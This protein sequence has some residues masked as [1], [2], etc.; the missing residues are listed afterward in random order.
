MI[1]GKWAEV[2]TNLGKTS[3]ND[4]IKMPFK[5]KKVGASQHKFFLKCI[6]VYR[7]FCKQ[8]WSWPTQACKKVKGSSIQKKAFLIGLILICTDMAMCIDSWMTRTVPGCP[9]CQGWGRSCCRPCPRPSPPSP[10]GSHLLLVSWC[11]GVNW[12]PLRLEDFELIL[13]GPWGIDL[14]PCLS[15]LRGRLWITPRE[16]QIHSLHWTSCLLG[17]GRQQGVHY[18]RYSRPKLH[19]SWQSP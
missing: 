2:W 18:S 7:K 13:L 14:I 1:Q 6:K 12:P 17:G 5:F 16:L 19:R 10:L 4:S 15:S 8:C 3:V 9:M 11:L